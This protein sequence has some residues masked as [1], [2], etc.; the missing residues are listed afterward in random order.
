MCREALKGDL[1][2]NLEQTAEVIARFVDEHDPCN[3][4]DAEAD[5]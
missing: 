1:E 3:L 4:R 5:S 2:S